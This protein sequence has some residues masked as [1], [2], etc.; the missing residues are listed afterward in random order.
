[1]T[2]SP[3]AAA[4]L[5]LEDVILGEEWRTGTHTV[6]AGQIAAFAEL[7]R[8]HHPLHTD[9]AYCRSRGFPAVIAHG[10]FG[11]SLMEGLKTELRLYDSTSIASLGW[12]KVRFRAPVL[13]GDKLHLR[14]R[15]TAKRP[16]RNP[17]RGVVTEFLELVNARG[18]VVIDAEHASLILTRNAGHA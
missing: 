10:L 13:A 6:T 8:D 4:S 17:D 18:E 16:S 12:D 1:M 5:F 15:F 11:L 14:M 3:P 9:A 7:T 2:A